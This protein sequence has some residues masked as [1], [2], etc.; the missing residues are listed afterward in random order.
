MARDLMASAD[1]LP[2]DF[3]NFTETVRRYI[4]E[5][6]RLAREQR[7]Q[8]TERNR[9]IDEGVFAA[10]N[11]REAN[12][13]TPIERQIVALTAEGHSAK[14]IARSVTTEGQ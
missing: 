9:L 6:Q 1:L 4:D 14:E 2:F 5:V 13:L 3:E 8:I 12:L 7:D 11:D 10:V